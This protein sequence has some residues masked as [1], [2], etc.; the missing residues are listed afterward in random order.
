MTKR[1]NKSASKASAKVT[2]LD[3]INK[4]LSEKLSQ[5]KAL[6]NGSSSY[7][8]GGPL[9]ANVSGDISLRQHYIDYGYSFNTQWDSVL[10]IG[11]NIKGG[12]ALDLVT[13][14][15]EELI[16]NDLDGK[17]KITR[18]TDYTYNYAT[19]EE[20]NQKVQIKYEYG[21]AFSWFG[22]RLVR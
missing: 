7:N 12:K 18:G 1:S 14:I 22:V 13:A 4:N 19:I 6:E 9:Y 15:F 17:L 10:T 2:L 16:N 8:I 5:Y 11:N 20:G 21:R 3:R